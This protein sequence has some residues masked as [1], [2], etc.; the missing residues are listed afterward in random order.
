[1]IATAAQIDSAAVLAAAHSEKL[2][3]AL[4]WREHFDPKNSQSLRD[5]WARSF[6]R[7]MLP[8]IST[9]VSN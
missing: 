8:Y 7:Q 4:A 6:F 2:G 9:T 1:M 3:I 5:E